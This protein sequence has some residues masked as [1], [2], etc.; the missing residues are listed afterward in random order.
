MK[1]IFLFI[2]F[3]I[4]VNGINAQDLIVTND[5]DSI[6]CKIAKIKAENITSYKKD[7]FKSSLIPPEKSCRIKRLQE[8]KISLQH[9]I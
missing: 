7:Y 9:R 8:N 6:N 1:H 4:L 5:G 3:S 2:L